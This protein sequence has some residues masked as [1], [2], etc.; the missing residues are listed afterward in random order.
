MNSP[1]L[2]RASS[3]S[4]FASLAWQHLD[5]DVQAED[6]YYRN[7]EWLLH[8]R[9]IPNPMTWKAESSIRSPDVFLKPTVFSEAVFK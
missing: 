5:H 9:N 7:H 8:V 4:A 3:G 1:F 2:E 6:H